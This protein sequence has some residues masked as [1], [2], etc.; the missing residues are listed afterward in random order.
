MKVLLYLG[1][2]LSILCVSYETAAQSHIALATRKAELQAL[3]ER[4]KKRDEHDRRQVQET[5]RRLGIP[6]RR[7]LPNGKVL[8]LQ[9][10]IPGIGPVFYLTYN[11]DAADT[12][13]TDEVWLGGS[14]GLSL[15]G[16]GLTVGEWDAGAILANHPD[17]FERVTQVDGATALSN[18][19]THVAGTM[20]GDGSGTRPDARGMA[21]NP[22]HEDMF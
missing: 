12:V 21:A 14:A 2:A 9:R 8:E 10:F 22:Y 19:S 11:V 7:E 6:I 16:N 15:D 17:L 3:S 4:L 5:A 18:H 20:I 1:I 13:S